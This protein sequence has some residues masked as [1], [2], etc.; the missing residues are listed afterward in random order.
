MAEVPED[1]LPV[2]SPWKLLLVVV[3][4]FCKIAP[5]L[6]EGRSNSPDQTLPVVLLF[7]ASLIVGLGLPD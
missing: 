6:G 4:P 7:V 5:K 1:L 2:S 3:A